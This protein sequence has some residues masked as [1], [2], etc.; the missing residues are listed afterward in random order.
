MFQLQGLSQ[1]NMPLKLHGDGCG[2][3]G[4]GA[5]TSA[6][7]GTSTGWHP[8]VDRDMFQ[9]QGLSQLNMLAQSHEDCARALTNAPLIKTSVNAIARTRTFLI[10]TSPFRPAAQPLRNA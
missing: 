8:Q 9:L 1:L 4:A 3:G 10:F 6:A 7:A 2:G 5:G